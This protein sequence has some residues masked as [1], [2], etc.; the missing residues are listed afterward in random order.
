MNKLNL[1]TGLKQNN[2]IYFIQLDD[3]YLYIYKNERVSIYP[4]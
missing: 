2:I 1:L 4:L 3:N